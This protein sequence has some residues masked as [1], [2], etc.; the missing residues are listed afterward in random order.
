MND[1][2]ETNRKVP[3][4][5]YGNEIFRIPRMKIEKAKYSMHYTYDARSGAAC[6]R[7]S[8]ASR[9]HYSDIQVGVNQ[10]VNLSLNLNASFLTAVHL[11]RSLLSGNIFDC[12]L[13]TAL[14]KKQ[15]Q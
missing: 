15:L 8:T 3:M 4:Y 10:C 11:F 1:E 12:S 9:R 2:F 5:Y 14:E 13:I 6:C 7:P